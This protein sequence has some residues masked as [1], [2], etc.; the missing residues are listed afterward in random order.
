VA[1]TSSTTK[2]TNNGSSAAERLRALGGPLIDESRRAGTAA[3]D[4][5][6]RQV[7]TLTDFQTKVADVVNVEPAASIT[8]AYAELTRELTAAQVSVAR[9]LLKV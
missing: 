2:S 8:S 7:K 9:T 3:L 6:E 5:Y 1:T 4:A